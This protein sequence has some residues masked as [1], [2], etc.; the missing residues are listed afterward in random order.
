MNWFCV[1]FCCQN[2]LKIKNHTAWNVLKNCFKSEIK[3]KLNIYWLFYCFVL[4]GLHRQW[5]LFFF[6]FVFFR[7][8]LNLSMRILKP[9][10][11]LT[12]WTSW[13]RSQTTFPWSF[14]RR[15]SCRSGSC[16]EKWPIRTKVDGSKFT[17]W[18]RGTTPTSFSTIT[19]THSRRACKSPATTTTSILSSCWCSASER[20]CSH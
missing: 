8:S 18:W 12:G 10:H 14:S 20:S 6:S 11:T 19:S 9:W 5:L 4:D 2:V 13:Q 1:L 3:S 17:L 7:Y 16:H 15:V